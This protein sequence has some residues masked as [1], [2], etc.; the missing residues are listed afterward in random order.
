MTRDNGTSR[1]R[2]EFSGAPFGLKVQCNCSKSGGTWTHLKSSWPRAWL[3]E[4]NGQEVSSVIP[5]GNPPVTCCG[6]F[7]FPCRRQSGCIPSKSTALHCLLLPPLLGHL[8]ASLLVDLR[9]PSKLR[10][11]YAPSFAV[12][13]VKTEQ[14]LPLWTVSPRRQVG[15]F[16]KGENVCSVT[17]RTAGHDSVWWGFSFSV[18]LN[19]CGERP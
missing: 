7:V 18:L 3:R 6:F 11:G 17:N 13:N 12:D 10:W 4:K 16:G 9:E 19:G 2:G 8:E 5:G 14:L 15:S 1:K